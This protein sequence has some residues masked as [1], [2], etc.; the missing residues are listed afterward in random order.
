[1]S[2]IRS[3]S[4][5]SPSRTSARVD[6]RRGGRGGHLR[7]GRRDRL[8][9]VRLGAPRAGAPDPRSRVAGPGR[10]PGA[11]RERAGRRPDRGH[12]P[13]SRPGALPQLRGRRVGHV[14]QRAVHRAGHQADR[15]LHVRAV[16][17]RAGLLHQDGSLARAA[18]R[19]A[20]ADDGG[21]QGLGA[22]RGHAGARVLGARRSALVTGAG[23][24]GLLAALI[25]RPAGA[26]GPRPRP[27]HRG[28]RSRSSCATSV[29]PTTPV[30]SPTSA[31]SP[32]SSSSAP[33]SGRSSSTRSARSAPAGWSA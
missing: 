5:R 17:H 29:P 15:R 18:G 6:P 12:R 16:A 1:M 33:A 11:D 3:A 25:G 14:P 21:D 9:R 8:G 32:T 10:G 7:H 2:R 30:P 31:S 19:A 23:P 13:T 28:R 4:R 26:R 24:I 20:R 27:R 22:R